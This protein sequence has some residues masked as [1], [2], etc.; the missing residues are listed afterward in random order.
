MEEGTAFAIES[1]EE[2]ANRMTKWIGKSLLFC[3]SFSGSSSCC[4]GREIS[5][6]NCVGME[7]LKEIRFAQLLPRGVFFF[8]FLRNIIMRGLYF[9]N[10]VVSSLFFNFHFGNKFVL[11]CYIFH[12]YLKLQL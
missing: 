12:K 8:V 5:S 3:C 2:A 1:K 6:F 4:C 7:M 10:E 11:F 9:Q